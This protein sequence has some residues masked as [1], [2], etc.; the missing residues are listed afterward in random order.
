MRPILAGNEGKRKPL[1]VQ[2]SVTDRCPCSCRHCGVAYQRRAGAPEPSLDD[3]RAVFADLARSGTA[4][5]DLFGGEPTV[6]QDLCAIV[7][8]A[9]AFGFRTFVETNG[10]FLDEPRVQALKDAGLDGLYVSLD[11]DEEAVHDRNRNRKGVFRRAVRGIGLCRRHG[12][13]VHVSYVPAARSDFESGRVNRFLDFAFAVG[14]QKVRILL[15]RYSGS[16]RL[17]EDAPFSGGR[18]QEL[19]RYLP[20]H[21]YG[22]VYFHSSDTPMEDITRCS[23]KQ[24]FCHITTRGDVLPCPYLPVVFGNVRR[25]PLAPIFDRIQQSPLMRM[26]GT[27]CLARDLEFVRSHL[28]RTTPERP[29]LHADENGRIL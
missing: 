20:W 16:M 23:A 18:D 3:L 13:P 11:H 6:R 12:M 1:V 21:V 14:A 7:R 24:Y 25:E 9:K 4:V 8:S 27:R 29:C 17:D 22:R 10:F 19:L 15:P 5:V 2:V 28:S 26:G